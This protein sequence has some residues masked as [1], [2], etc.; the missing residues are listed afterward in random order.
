MWAMMSPDRLV[1]PSPEV[2]RDWRRARNL[3]AREAGALAGVTLRAWQMY[4]SGDRRMRPALWR[5]LTAARIS[6]FPR[7]TS[8]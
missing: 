4:E 7:P 2:V 3:S 1:P 8:R 6:S 5:L